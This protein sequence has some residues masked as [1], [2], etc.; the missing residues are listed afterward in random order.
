MK[1][2]QEEIKDLSQLHKRIQNDVSG[3]QKYEEDILA[4]ITVLEAKLDSLDASEAALMQKFVSH[5]DIKPLFERY[6]SS[7]KQNIQKRPEQRKSIRTNLSRYQTEIEKQKQHP[8]KV[9]ERNK[10][11]DRGN[12]R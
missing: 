11:H 4:K 1:A 12:E 9:P 2:L 7:V 5:K 10:K 6:R 8:D 3:L